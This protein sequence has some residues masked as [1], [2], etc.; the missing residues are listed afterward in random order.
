[1]HIL[2]NNKGRISL[3]ELLAL[4]FLIPAIL[5]LGFKGVEWYYNSMRNG[6]DG[7]YVNTAESIA[8]INSLNGVQC[9]VDGCGGSAYCTHRRGDH[10]VGYY[11]NISHTIVGY[12]LAGYNQAKIMHVGE[13]KYSGDEGTMI[14]E[15]ISGNGEIELNW[16]K[17]K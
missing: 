8:V 15:V 9:P 10:F 16:V 11:D 3:I 7:M 12:K 6:N 17:G 13:K 5:F 2:K 1:M 14:I 4:A